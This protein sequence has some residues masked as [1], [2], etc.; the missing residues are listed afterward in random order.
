MAAIEKFKQLQ[1]ALPPSTAEN[2]DLRE[3][4]LLE[5]R[6]LVLS[7]E[8]Q[9]NVVERVCYQLWETAAIK[10]GV[11]LGV[12][13]LLKDS[14]QPKS[15]AELAKSTGADPLLL[16]RILR[17]LGAYGAV[18][19]IDVDL[20]AATIV[21]DT[22]AEPKNEAALEMCFDFLSPG[23]LATPAFLKEIGHQNPTSPTKTAFAK[24]YDFPNGGTIWEILLSTP[25]LT[26]VNAYMATFNEGHKDWMSLYPIE[27]QLISGA[28]EGPE[29]VFMVDVGGGGGH[30]AI[31]LKKRF[32]TVPGRIVVEDLPQGLPKDGVEGTEGIELLAH[33]FME[34]QPIKG[35][36]L[37]YLRYVPHDWS[38]EVCTKLLRRLRDA[39]TPGYSRVVINEWIVP[40][41]GA[42][43]FM[44]A[45]D[46]N[47]MASSGGFERTEALHREY[48]EAAGLRITGIWRPGDKVSESVIEAQLPEGS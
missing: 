23:W 26:A 17:I 4:L 48:I 14:P 30:Q 43:K 46:M 25:H 19:E 47:M 3:D 35:A 34:E 11:N 9:D 20:W 13:H 41:K 10:I 15:T 32:P 39:M 31:A 42:S 36:R 16:G 28:K 27:E 40:A 1:E 8:R 2:V 12:F 18:E 45:Q 37:Y 6:K 29:S 22:F 24:A 7:L 5:A 38:Q 44:T 33:N 21:S